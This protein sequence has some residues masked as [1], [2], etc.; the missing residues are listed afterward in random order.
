MPLRGGGEGRKYGCTGRI[1]KRP[2]RRKRDGP[3]ERGVGEI[4]VSAKRAMSP[5]PASK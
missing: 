5:A 2:Y 3:G 4:A 1:T